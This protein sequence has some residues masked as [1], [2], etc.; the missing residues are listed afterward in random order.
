MIT[1]PSQL[2]YTGFIVLAAL[3]A[4][5]AADAQ[6]QPNLNLAADCSAAAIATGTSPSEINRN[7]ANQHNSQSIPVEMSTDKWQKINEYMN[8]KDSSSGSSSTNFDV[9]KRSDTPLADS[10]SPQEGVEHFTY[11][12]WKTGMKEEYAN[13]RRPE[14][15]KYLPE[16]SALGTSPVDRECDLANENKQELNGNMEKRQ[17]AADL[18]FISSNHDSS[19][20]VVIGTNTVSTHTTGFHTLPHPIREPV[21]HSSEE[22][23]TILLSTH[24]AIT[25]KISSYSSS[26]IVWSTTSWTISTHSSTRVVSS[27]AVLPTSHSIASTQVSSQAS[28]SLTTILLN[29]HLPVST[30]SASKASTNTSPS[31]TTVLLTTHVPVI[32]TKEASQTSF[33][34]S[35][36]LT[37]IILTTYLPIN[38]GG[39]PSV[40]TIILT[41]NLPT[42]T[43][44]VTKET[45]SSKSMSSLTTSL[46]TKPAAKALS[47][48][49]DSLTTIILTTHLPTNVGASP[50]I[51]TIILTTQLSMATATSQS[52]TKEISKA[53]SSSST[54]TLPS[55]TT[56][57][58]TT[59][60]PVTTK[61]ASSSSSLT[62]VYLTTYLPVPTALAKT[63]ATIGEHLPVLPTIR[64]TQTR[65]RHYTR[66]VPTPR[67]ATNNDN[68]L[69]KNMNNNNAIHDSMALP[70]NLITTRITVPTSIHSPKRTSVAAAPP[71]DPEFGE[72]W[73]HSNQFSNNGEIGMAANN[74]NNG[75]FFRGP[76]APGAPDSFNDGPTDGAPWQS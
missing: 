73:G 60:V 22:L 1:S 65:S 40:T 48:S 68:P 32:S 9:Q 59:H 31:P 66:I 17:L 70:N 2:I 14:D 15:E 75:G 23:T 27:S 63:T 44:A 57:L 29:T 50:S 12:R 7:C 51:T 71:S 72:H 52:V 6:Q 13:I 5:T 62:T 30:K 49:K 10:S 3:T 33:K 37:T 67:S 34:A 36:S 8:N 47:S 16:E 24:R 42:T 54:K 74:G 55:L 41:T 18:E 4:G 76:S 28:P 35:H 21:T 56:V 61:E 38:S 69:S 20:Q 64:I 26:T 53:S 43:K 46:L 58:L 25:T 11:N 19:I 45:S 39:S